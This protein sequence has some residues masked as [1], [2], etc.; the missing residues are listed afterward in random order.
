M[1]D[2]A[3]AVCGTTPQGVPDIRSLEYSDRA[4]IAI[5]DMVD[6]RRLRSAV[7]V[8]SRRSAGMG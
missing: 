3:L 4:A 5:G 8:D 6:V 2:D 7:G 1:G